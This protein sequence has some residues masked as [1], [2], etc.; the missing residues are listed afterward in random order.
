MR[1]AVERFETPENSRARFGGKGFFLAKLREMHYA[2]PPFHVLE[3]TVLRRTEISE[4]EIETLLAHLRR[5]AAEV[6]GVEPGSVAFAVRSSAP[7]SM[8]GMMDTILGV[9]L[10][11]SDLP[12]LAERLGG[13]DAAWDMLITGAEGMCRHIAGLPAPEPE[14]ATPAAYERLVAAFEK[15]TGTDFPRT[16]AAQVK[17]AVD[18]VAASW[19]NSRAREY[20]AVHGISEHDCPSVVI[21]AMAYGTAGSGSGSGVV[22]SHDPLTGVRGLHGEFLGG[23]TGESLVA[24]TATP[25]VVEE[26]AIIAPTAH[27]ELAAYTDELFSWLSVLVEVEFVVEHGSLWLVQ[28]RPAIAADRVHNTITVD[29]WRAGILDRGDALERLRLD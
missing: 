29:A 2:V 25:T 11:P 6:M 21:Q 23:R 8:P 15:A 1:P 12:A 14:P 24:G 26:L 28:V 16:P 4:P 7:V 18:A 17:R 20:R 22:F 13:P 10:S 27:A 19:N 5:E 9:G 3:G